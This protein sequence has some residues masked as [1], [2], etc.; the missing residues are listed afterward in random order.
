MPPRR[1][2]RASAAAAAA[3]TDAAREVAAR[4]AR[5]VAAAQHAA[6]ALAPLPN[7]L[8]LHILSLLPVDCRLLC[9][10]VCRSWRAALEERSLW[11]RLDLSASGV[12]PKREATDALLHAAAARAGG[13]LMALDLR[14]C[15]RVTLDALLAAVT[16]NGALRELRTC[17]IFRR[18]DED[19]PLDTDAL[20]A[21]LRAAP[22]L[23]VCEADVECHELM[24]AH[25][26]LRNEP[27][28]APLHVRSLEFHHAEGE[29]DEAAVVALAS[30]TAAHAHLRLLELLHTPL[31]TAA[32]LD[33]V[34]DAVLTRRLTRLRL[35]GCNLSPDSAPALVRL[36]GGGALEELGI[37][38]GY[39]VLLD[40][41]AALALGNA[42]RSSTTLTAL[43]LVSAEM[44][45]NPAA[46]TALLAALTGHPSLRS[47]NF[48][49]NAV[50]LEP[51]GREEVGAALGALVAA[52]APT[53]Q[54]VNLLCCWLGDAGLRPLFNALPHNTHLHTLSCGVNRLSDDFVRER[55]LP[56]VRANHSLRELK[57]G[58]E[59]DAAREAEAHVQRR[60]AG[61]ADGAQ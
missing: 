9:A 40:V 6:P 12:S 55:L 5:I 32:A 33:A 20:E 43:S 53:L 25:R 24:L 49:Y 16:A 28:F 48:S 30:D 42:L 50:P 61:E 21:L 38:C 54:E 31:N 35:Q 8:V 34:V 44:W 27:P 10:G 3:A 19:S 29:R 11:L 39:V 56:A 47:L 37:Y 58:L 18:D 59:T 7:A 15:T 52:N 17:S 41:P 26:L 13:E 46:G 60:A 36:V 4:S 22:R 2:T 45:L 14:S 23:A 1:N 51:A 57:T